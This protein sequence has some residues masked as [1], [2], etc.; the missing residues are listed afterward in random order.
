MVDEP[1]DGF[2]LVAH[3]DNFLTVENPS[4]GRS[5][6]VNHAPGFSNKCHKDVFAI[7]TTRVSIASGV[8]RP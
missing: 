5:E 1:D 4:P 6:R 7:S 8:L 2:H 3:A